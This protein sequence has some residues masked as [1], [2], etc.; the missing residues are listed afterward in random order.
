MLT[1]PV[2]TISLPISP[3]AANFID[4][5]LVVHIRACVLLPCYSFLSKVLSFHKF[6]YTPMC[7]YLVF[8]ILCVCFGRDAG[9]VLSFHY[10]FGTTLR[11][12]VCMASPFA[13]VSLA[14][15]FNSVKCLDYHPRFLFQTY[16]VYFLLCFGVNLSLVDNIILYL[17]P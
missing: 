6:S 9:R 4:V 8:L 14:F 3:T 11:S 10:G 12:S 15:E 13:R 5:H 1:L 17:F 16:V 7:F 2:N